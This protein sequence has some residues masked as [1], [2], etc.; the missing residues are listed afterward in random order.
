MKF[1]TI[2]ACISAIALVAGVVL[3]VLAERPCGWREA[4]AVLREAPLPPWPPGYEEWA[5][6]R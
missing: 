1:D 4:L 5:R 6:G 2:L 3:L